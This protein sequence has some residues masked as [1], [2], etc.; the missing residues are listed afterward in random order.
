MINYEY[1]MLKKVS[2]NELEEWLNRN[3]MP[4]NWHDRNRYS[5]AYTEMPSSK[6]LTWW[7]KTILG[8]RI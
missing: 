7:R 1:E 4:K 6:F 3:P 2:V 5:W 8:W